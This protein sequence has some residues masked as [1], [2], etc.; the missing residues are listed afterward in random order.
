MLL[1][2]TILSTVICLLA[3][4][5]FSQQAKPAYQYELDNANKA[6]NAKKYNTAATIFKK[7]YPKVKEETEKQNVLFMI[8]ESYRLSNNYTQAIKWFEDAINAKYPEPSILYSYGNL[9]KYFERYEDA[10]RAFYDYSFEVPDDINGKRAFESCAIA[11]LWKSNP[12]KFNINS[13]K[14]INTEFSD[15]SPYYSN[16]KLFWSSTRKESQGNLIFEW[17]G[18]KMCD[19]FEVDYTNNAIGGKPSNLKG[20]INSNY[21]DGALCAD[22][23]GNVIY[24]TQCNGIDGKGINCK[25]FV[26]YK[27]NNL[28]S[29]PTLLPFNSDSFSCGQPSISK[30]GKK[31]Y[32][33]S[34]MPGGLGEK[35]IYVAQYDEIKATWQKP[36]N[37]GNTVNT[38][39]DDMFPYISEDNELYYASKGKGGLG[40]L[41]LFKTADSI[42]TYKL[43]VNLQYPINSGGDDF[44][45]SFIPKWQWSEEKPIAFFSSNRIN[46]MGDDD[47]YSISIKPYVFLVKG[48]VLDREGNAV[49][50]KANVSLTS[51]KG[52]PIFNILT[53]E[54]GLFTGEIPLNAFQNLIVNKASYFA[55]TPIGISS[56]GLKKDSVLE[57]TIYLDAIPS[58]ETDFTL[59]GIFYDVDKY[60]LRPESKQI[61]DSL[62]II[63]RNNP[64]ITIEIGSHTDS[65][66]PA[67]Y[68]LTLSKKRAQSCVDYLLASKIAKDRLIAVGYGETKLV[69]D[70]SDGEDCTEEQHQQNRRTTFRV[71]KTDYK[72]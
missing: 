37:L 60:D 64:T 48:K 11:Q 70:C 51:D 41:D 23:S 38:Y 57:L 17:T 47:I 3:Q 27:Q 45:I 5:A 40:G 21:N 32:F 72:R 69:N 44:G 4:L 18:Q 52:A 33:S 61:L 54:N 39:A 10:G 30:D 25:I 58:P 34:D 49:L 15:Y 67:D 53:N 2:K 35:D 71:L 50:S 46:G 24:F 13:V 12:Q 19:L 68:N 14:E 59:Q 20:K 31:L 36:I 43:P 62:A 22:T 1:K 66:A 42:N 65:R 56:L 7:A 9:L 16:G 63:L 29:D 28:W 26:S 55:S 8:A 6:F